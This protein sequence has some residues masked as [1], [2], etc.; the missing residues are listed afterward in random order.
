MRLPFVSKQNH[1]D[2]R[3][4]EKLRGLL[5]QL[6]V[7]LQGVAE[8]IPDPE[9]VID[10]EEP[11]LSPGE[12][13]VEEIQG[14]LFSQLKDRVFAPQKIY[15][16]NSMGIHEETR[17][18]IVST[19]SEQI[20]KHKAGEAAFLWIEDGKP[21]YVIEDK[22]SGDDP[23]SPFRIPPPEKYGVTPTRL[24]GMGVA[25]ARHVADVHKIM[26]R[27]KS[28][29]WVK[30]GK[31]I[32]LIVPIV[33]VVLATFLIGVVL[34]GDGDETPV[35]TVPPTGDT[36]IERPKAVLEPTP[37]TI[38]ELPRGIPIEE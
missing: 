29:N 7:P 32:S 6:G 37:E 16:V 25:H 10:T 18:D 19:L 2:A 12:D 4:I 1:S 36:G 14:N 30:S 9:P 15:I 3:E 8:E 38:K 26:A 20:A 27:K 31:M 34:L 28:S 17:P 13:I 24:Y 22:P 23:F 33:I 5:Q 21:E 11:G 35:S